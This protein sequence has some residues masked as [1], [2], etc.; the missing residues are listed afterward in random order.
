MQTSQPSSPIANRIVGS[1]ELACWKD[2]IKY[3]P[4]V[5]DF[6]IWH[7]WMHRW[8]GVISEVN[9]DVIIV[10]KENLPKLLFTMPPSDYQKNSVQLSVTKIKFSRGGEYHLLQNGVWYVDI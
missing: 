2:L 7:G 4:K 3:K 6:I 5:G 9:G 10:I 1:L 8:Y